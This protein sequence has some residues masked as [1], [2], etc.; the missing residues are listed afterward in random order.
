MRSHDSEVHVIGT[1]IRPDGHMT[2]NMP[3]AETQMILGQELLTLALLR[4]FLCS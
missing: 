4:M 3:Q 2:F 1:L